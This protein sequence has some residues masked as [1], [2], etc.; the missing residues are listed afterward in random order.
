MANDLKT[1]P[2]Y[3]DT[4]SSD[5]VLSDRPMSIQ[6]I[7]FYSGTNTDNLTIED[8]NGVPIIQLLA[9]Q[10]WSPTDA[11]TFSN[12]PYTVDVSDGAY[13]ATARAFI[14]V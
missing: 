4:F 6:S 2:I 14:Y 8:K 1:N 7:Q 3:L 13:A 9:N 5:I 11:I 10:S 12:P